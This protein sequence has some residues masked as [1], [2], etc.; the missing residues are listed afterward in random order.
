MLLTVAQAAEMLAVCRKTLRRA[1]DR[2]ELPVVR[3]GETARADRIHPNDLE[4]YINKLRRARPTCP[5]SVVVPLGQWVQAAGDSELS[6][7]LDAELHG[8]KRAKRRRN[9]S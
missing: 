6:A 5:S 8:P 7:L 1:I 3:L 9:V 2:G 4:N